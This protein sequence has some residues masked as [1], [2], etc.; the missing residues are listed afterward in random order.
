MLADKMKIVEIAADVIPKPIS[1][2]IE[3][4][5]VLFA[6]VVVGLILTPS[7][8]HDDVTC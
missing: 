6:V 8:L 1:T 5:A 7:W 2:A 4:D 3:N